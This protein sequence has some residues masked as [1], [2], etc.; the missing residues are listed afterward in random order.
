MGEEA[1]IG[2]LRVTLV[3]MLLANAAV[4]TTKRATV[5]KTGTETA[6]DM[7]VA[8]RETEKEIEKANAIIMVAEATNE[9]ENKKI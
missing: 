9:T 4:T 7:V 3:S 1:A 8:I 6:K 2:E 5:G